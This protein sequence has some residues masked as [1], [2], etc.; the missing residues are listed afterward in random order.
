MQHYIFD[1]NDDDD[2]DDDNG[3]YNDNDKD[4]D[5]DYT[6]TVLQCSAV[7]WQIYVLDKQF[8]SSYLKLFRL[9]IFEFSFTQFV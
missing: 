8:F 9:N 7:Q 6:D 1:D 2:D 4:D 3:K 5:Y